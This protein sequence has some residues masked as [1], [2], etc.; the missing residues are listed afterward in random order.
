MWKKGSSTLS[1][2]LLVAQLFL[3]LGSGASWNGCFGDYFSIQVEPR[4]TTCKDK[5]RYSI[6]PNEDA[7][8]DSLMLDPITGRIEGVFRPNWA[9]YGS[10]QL[11]TGQRYRITVLVKNLEDNSVEKVKISIYREECK[12]PV[13]SNFVIVDTKRNVDVRPLIDDDVINLGWLR[14]R[15]SIRAGVFPEIETE[16]F[17]PENIVDKVEFYLD[18]KKVRTEHFPPYALGGDKTGDHNCG[19]FWPF[20]ISEGK[21]TLTAIPYGEGGQPGEAMTVKFTITEC[22]GHYC[23]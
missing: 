21:H 19:D 18:G 15:F 23:E 16:T 1:V 14:D 9:G 12:E 2:L 17:Y 20:D 5:V 4:D 8:P 3:L 11:Q 6:D 7:L 10:R 22:S 13:I